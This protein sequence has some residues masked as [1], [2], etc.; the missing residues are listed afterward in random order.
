MNKK[1]AIKYTF[2]IVAVITA[3]TLVFVPVY[4]YLQKSMFINLEQRAIADFCNEIVRNVDLSDKDEIAEYLNVTNEKTYRVTVYDVNMERL[5]TNQPS[6]KNKKENNVISPSHIKDYKADSYPVYEKYD[7]GGME[8]ISLRRYVEQGDS[9][10]YISI[11]EALRNT[12]QIFSYT[13]EV[14]VGI[15][16]LYIMV[17]GLVLFLLTRRLTT[18]I[19]SLN[20]VVKKIAEKDYSV[21]YEGKISRDEVGALA[22]NF[23]EMADTI[24][25][26][27]SSISNYNFL[28]K[29]D[30]DHLKE[31]E[32]MRSQL[33]RNTTHELKTPLA[34]ISS[35]VEMMNCTDDEE[36]R[37][38]Y[39]DSAMAEI[40]KLSTMITGILQYSVAE[41]KTFKTST[42]KINLSSKIDELCDKISG[43]IQSK[44]LSFGRDIHPNLITAI[45]ETHIEHIFNN[46]IMNAVKHT[47]KGGMISVTL[48][49]RDDRIRLSVYNEGAPIPNE[50]LEKIWTEFYSENNKS[51]DNVG[52]GLFIVKEI[53]L[54]NHL[55]CG[56][57]N[58]DNGVEFWFDFA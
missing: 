7:E 45:T 49:R 12:E 51:N 13:N 32:Q 5:F 2:L 33:V 50:K 30:I 56:A 35:Q 28:L 23:N 24:Q 25:D 3:V 37:R 39:Y 4:T 46:Y 57:F 31:Y 26:N 15:L 17:C 1:I 16:L 21:R 22:T 53:S 43:T 58:C 54:I 40:R 8:D 41:S 34:I 48:K 36:K 42:E 9:E 47:K 14:L 6:P 10:F 27:I 18:S 11:H 19:R 44:K 38:Y 55:D 20:K 52:L 29:E